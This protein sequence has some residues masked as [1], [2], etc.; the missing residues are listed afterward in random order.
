MKINFVDL[1]RQ[2]LSIKDEIDFAIK[3]TLE[4]TSFILGDDV[5]EFEKNFSKIHNVKNCISV[6]NGTDSLFIIMKSLGIGSGDEV[7]TVC[8]SWISSSETIS[9]TG[10]KP[11]FID[12]DPNT[13]SLDVDKLENLVNDRTK[14][15]MPVHLFGN[16]CEMNEILSIASK[17][18]LKIIEDCAQA[19]LANYNDNL[20]GTFGIA[21]SF[22]FFP[23][24]NLGAYGDAG[25]IL[26]DDDDLA[27]KCRM[28]A[29]HGALKKHHH[30]I[31][32]INSRMDNLQAAILNVKL[33]YLNEWTLKRQEAAK[34]YKENLKNCNVTCLEET[35]NSKSSYH[36]F[37][38]ICEDRD[39]LKKFLL[40]NGISCAIHYPKIIPLQPAYSQ[41]N[42]AEK[43]FPVGSKLQHK[44]LSLPIFPEIKKIE[45]DYIT[46]LISEFYSKTN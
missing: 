44:I 22:S 15:I 9:L 37:V 4:N 16:P 20:V 13:L 35:L 21:S 27:M 34:I 39:D 10:A 32:G 45:I 25:A 17:Y 24:K 31:E 38:I 46:N 19:H 33:K 41:Y 28:F 3:N 6:A 14:A 42:Y 2:Y 30:L 23:G 5:R 26:T 29:R 36:L 43:D 18:N 7:I 12:V 1:K 8:N 40:K 11:V